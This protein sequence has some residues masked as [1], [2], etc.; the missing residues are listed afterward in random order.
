MEC[1]EGFVANV[2]YDDWKGTVA[3]D[4]YVKEDIRSWLQKEGK[5]GEDDVVCGIQYYRVEKSASLSVFIFEGQGGRNMNDARLEGKPI[6]LKKLSLELSFQDFLQKFK[7]L[8][9]RLS[10]HGSIDGEE[11]TITK[12]EEWQ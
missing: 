3:A 6:P 10:F 12:V 11:V 5:L 1:T 4:D 7:R 9:V 8:D 2:Q